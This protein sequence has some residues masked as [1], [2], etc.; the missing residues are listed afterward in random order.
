V[1]EGLEAARTALG[2]VRCYLVGGAVRDALQGR[3]EAEDVDLVVDGDVR[4]A[5]RA[6]A[7]SADAVA[8]ELSDEF[9]AWRVVARSRRWQADLNPLRGGSI[10]ADLRLRDFTVNAIA[11]PLAGGELIDPCGGVT[12]LANGVLRLVA[13]HAIANDPLRALRLVR[14]ACE[15]DLEP[16]AAAQAAA[17][18]SAGALTE[19]APE[20]SLIELRR[21]LESERAVAGVRLAGQLG[22]TAVLL[23]ELEQLRGV[24]QNRFHHLDVYEHTLA[25]LQAVIELQRDP[26]AALGAEHAAAI[27]QLL[28]EPLADG[29]TR[30]GGLRFGALLHDIAKPATRGVTGEGR[31][32]FLGHDEHGAAVA[33]A[34]LGRLRA[35]E[36][37]RSH[38]AALTRHHLRL[39]FLVHRAPLSA[40]EVFRYLDACG[41]VA[42]DVTLLSV[43]DRLATRGDDAEQAIGKHL[44]LARGLIGT[45][46]DWHAG[47]RPQP[48]VRGDVLA[49]E[50][51]IEPGPQVGELLAELAAAQFAG[52]IASAP[53]AI[54][55]ARGLIP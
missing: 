34:V 30:S 17:E 28:A 6:L 39:G 16:D 36:R 13:D 5:A 14:L 54:A 55:Y 22:L 26:S 1:S 32:T 35:S 12:D 40:R 9:G 44:D 45:A 51:A 47:G 41:S 50:L 20:R 52:E 2:D 15:L 29:T 48:L 42:A 38:V 53:E 7:A 37:L 31:V 43:A 19:V 25:V 21:I 27:T 24:E 46:L 33:E 23:P 10:E 18:R 49:A 11:Q 8:F 3:A 4:A